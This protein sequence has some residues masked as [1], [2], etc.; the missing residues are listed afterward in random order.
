VDALRGLVVFDEFLIG[1][2][3]IPQ[4]LYCGLVQC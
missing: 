2:F 4:A 3:S 1:F